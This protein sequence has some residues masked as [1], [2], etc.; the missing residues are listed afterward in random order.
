MTRKSI[1]DSRRSFAVRAWRSAHETTIDLRW[2]GTE[3]RTCIATVW[4]DLRQDDRTGQDGGHLATA[5][6]PKPGQ[7]C[8]S[9]P[10]REGQ[11]DIGGRERGLE[12]AGVGYRRACMRACVDKMT[13]EP[14]ASFPVLP[15]PSFCLAAVEKK[16]AHG[17]EIKAGVG[18]T[19][20]EASEHPDFVFL[21]NGGEPGNESALV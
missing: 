2:Y 16:K 14:L 18:K 1:Q 9:S 5:A 6:H 20:N 7:S 10:V 13:G 4:T 8:H 19:G 21:A 11:L 15:T 3:A 17:C 12:R